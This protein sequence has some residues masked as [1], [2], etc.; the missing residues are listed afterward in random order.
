MSRTVDEGASPLPFNAD[1]ERAAIGVC[2]IS[3]DALQLV[4]RLLQPDDFHNPQHAEAFAAVGAL[5]E[6]S[7]EVNELALADEL[8][9]RG[10]LD[11]SAKLLVADLVHEAGSTRDGEQAARIVLDKSR[12]RRVLQ[13]ASQ[14]ERAGMNGQSL[15]DLAAT[16]DELSALVTASSE[17]R[18]TPTVIDG[19]SFIASG[20]RTNNAPVWGEGERVLQARGES[21]LIVGP[22]GVGK[23]TLVQQYTLAR[24]G[25]RSHVLGFP[26]EP[27][28]QRV[29]LIA[30]D[31]PPQAARS[32]ARMVRDEDTELLRE[33]L[34]VWPGPLPFDLAQR[35]SGLA[36]LA[37]E[38]GAGTVVIDSLK[39]AALDLGKDETGSRLNHALQLALAAGVE[40]VALHHQRKA[41]Q[42]GGKPT[43]LPDVYGSTW[44]TAGVGSV[45]LLWGEPGDPVVEVTHLKQPLA[46]IGPLRVVHDH[47]RGESTI[48]EPHDLLRFIEA[49]RGGVTVQEVA[50]FLYDSDPPTRNE[51]EKAR[52]KLREMTPGLL[53]EQEGDRGGRGESRRPT[54]WF[55]SAPD[56]A[57]SDNHADNHAATTPK[58]NHAASPTITQNRKTAG[59]DNHADDLFNHA[60]GQSRSTPSLEG[61]REPADPAEEPWEDDPEDGSEQSVFDHLSR[62][63]G[64]EIIEER[65][66]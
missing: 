58:D 52:R 7:E 5:V 41:Q 24:I 9:R 43:K 29:M 56:E 4:T 8:D 21:L 57:P 40:V 23:T 12:R 10:R 20:A 49:A 22:A 33:R 50:A 62:E 32:M 3:P 48:F 60:P 14:I 46:D 2:L 18:T 6:R 16:T 55:R 25:A 26:V 65:T 31:R 28:T 36:E 19:A 59:Q 30:A 11:C 44:I 38:H 51:V 53:Y 54:R 61:E 27:E 66:A 34:I 64:A 35:P 42:G 45:L 13:L 37:A 17:L 15:A 1:A 63:L 39:D 47:G